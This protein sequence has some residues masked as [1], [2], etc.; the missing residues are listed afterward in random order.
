M[1]REES[2][3]IMKDLRLYGFIES[4]DEIM[5]EGRRTRKLTEKIILD[6]LRAE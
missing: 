5:E 3:E 4:Y 6:F 2:I 1:T